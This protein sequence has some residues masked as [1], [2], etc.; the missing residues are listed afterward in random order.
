[1]RTLGKEGAS[2]GKG[3]GKE[4]MTGALLDDTKK[5]ADEVTGKVVGGS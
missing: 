3:E 1:M 4:G 2:A 5:K